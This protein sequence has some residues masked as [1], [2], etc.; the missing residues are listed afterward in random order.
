MPFAPGHAPM[1]GRPKKA[2]SLRELLRNHPVKD[3]KQLVQKAYEMA[4]DGSIQWAE[5]IAKHSGEGADSSALPEG[6]SFREVTIRE[7]I[8]ERQAP[9][10]LPD[11]DSAEESELSGT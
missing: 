7:I 5:W 1:G 3:K 8:V 4:I 11:F 2:A 10:A 6:A 9:L